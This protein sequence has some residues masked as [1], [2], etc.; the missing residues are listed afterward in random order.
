MNVI[1]PTKLVMP[2]TTFTPD[3]T[4]SEE[5]RM[6]AV[7]LFCGVGGL[8]Y[9]MRQ[10]GLEVV[11]GYDID[12]SCQYAYETNNPG[13]KFICQ[14]VTLL[15]AEELNSHWPEGVVRILVGCAP[16]QP[17]SAVAAKAKKVRGQEEIE[18][19]WDPLR[20]FTRLILE[21]LP[22]VVSM[23]NVTRLANRTK[24]PVYGEFVDALTDAGYT[25]T[26]H[27]PFGPDYGIPQTR[28]RLVLFASRKGEVALPE[29]THATDEYVGVLEKIGGLKPLEAGESDPDDPMHIAA[30][31]SEINLKRAAASKQ[32]GDWSDW[33]DSLLLECHKKKS[34]KSFPTVYGRMTS[35]SPAPTLTTQFFKIGTGR[36]VHPTQNRGLS[37][38]EGAIIQTFPRDYVFAPKNSKINM[39]VMGRHIGNAVPPILGKTI[40]ASI[41]KHWNHCLIYTMLSI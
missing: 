11:A 25:V 37:L 29:K 27:R 38:R 6:V 22:D 35:E 19:S 16:C 36:F 1:L 18:T 40:G 15:T 31:L 4:R 39:T 34:G 20:A 9:G 2:V 8:T 23:E 5:Q 13:T 10:A 17:F 14:D 33:P 28:R 21:T 32:G 24:N 26:E 3:E 7:D 12:G 30:S 41:I